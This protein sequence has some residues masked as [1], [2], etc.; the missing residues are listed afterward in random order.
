MPAQRAQVSF[1]MKS[2]FL[3]T[4]SRRTMTPMLTFS[5]APRKPGSVSKGSSHH[6][7]VIVLDTVS[8][9]YLIFFV[10]GFC[11]EYWIR[12]LSIPV[13]GAKCWE[14]VW[15]WWWWW[16]FQPCQ[17]TVFGI[18]LLFSILG[19]GG[20]VLGRKLTYIYRSKENMGVLMWLT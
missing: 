19:C 2:S 17:V 1:R 14:P 8:V 20:R 18:S 6:D 16:S 9:A 4:S 10:N 7:A 3:V 11:Y 12:I 13:I 5:L 15:G